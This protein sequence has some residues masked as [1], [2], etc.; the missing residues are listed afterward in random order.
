[1]MLT[2]KKKKWI[3]NPKFIHY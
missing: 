2:S 1:M 3:V